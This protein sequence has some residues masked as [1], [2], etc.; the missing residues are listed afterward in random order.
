LNYRFSR[1]RTVTV[2]EGDQAEQTKTHY[3]EMR[4][5]TSAITCSGPALGEIVTTGEIV[6]QTNSAVLAGFRQTVR[7]WR[8]RPIVEIEIELD[9]RQMPDAEPW[10]NYYTARFA[11]HDE[12]ASLTRSAMMGAHETAEERIESLHYLEIATPEQR[13]TIL[14]PGLPFYRKTGA[15]MI[16][17]LLVV[18]RETER[19][20]RFTIAVDQDYPMQSALD[21][22]TPA[23]V[24]PVSAGPPRSG[25]A[26]WFFHLGTRQVQIV[27]M[28]PLAPETAA[29]P[30]PEGLAEGVSARAGCGC[31]LRLVETE[32][33][34]VRAR[35]RCFPT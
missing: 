3:A 11:W 18:P 1:E 27:Q 9:V 13:T 34:P 24:V 12:S 10:H 19:K 20:F 31:A 2:G 16:D 6:D 17:S 28:L 35:P 26:G 14:A 30:P 7:V 29:P 32:G 4:R 8:G 15:R 22:L 23:V 25:L 5:S 21:A 33:R